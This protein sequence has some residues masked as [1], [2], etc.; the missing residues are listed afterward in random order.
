MILKVLAGRIPKSVGTG[1]SYIVWPRTSVSFRSVPKNVTGVPNAEIVPRASP[2][3]TGT[4]TARVA[5]ASSGPGAEETE[6]ILRANK[7]A[8]VGVASN[9][10]SKQHFTSY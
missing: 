6:T 4:V 3:I 9:M 7:S 5:R 8:S 10:N 1:L 2:V